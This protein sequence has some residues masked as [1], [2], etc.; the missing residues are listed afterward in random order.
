M[1]TQHK[2]IMIAKVRQYNYNDVIRH[3]E[4]LEKCAHSGSNHDIVAEMKHIVP[5]F[6]SQNSEFEKIDIEIKKEIASGT[7]EVDS[8]TTIK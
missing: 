2:K 6:K 7:A 5:E 4:L 8:L 1:S 3:L